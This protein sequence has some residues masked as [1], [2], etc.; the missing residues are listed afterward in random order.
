MFYSPFAAPRKDTT[1]FI[2]R[3]ESV[4]LHVSNVS[5]D[6]F[7]VQVNCSLHLKYNWEG[8]FQMGIDA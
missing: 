1:L 5:D 2:A 3:A 6:W 4:G 8:N 7:R